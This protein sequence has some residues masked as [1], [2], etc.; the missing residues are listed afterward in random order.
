MQLEINLRL[1]D[2]VNGDFVAHGKDAVKALRIKLDKERDAEALTRVRATDDEMTR[3]A[4]DRG[5]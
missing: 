1:C 3:L 2:M 4:I 5:D